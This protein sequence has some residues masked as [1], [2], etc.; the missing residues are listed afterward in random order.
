MCPPAANGRQLALPAGQ[1]Y[2]REPA[3]PQTANRDKISDMVVI[4]NVSALFTYYYTR[5]LDLVIKQ[6]SFLMT[7]IIPV[8]YGIETIVTI[9]HLQVAITLLNSQSEE[10]E[11][12]LSGCE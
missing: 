3:M 11:A 12:P 4:T 8:I 6:R 10:L 2:G 9:E 7:V 5:Y 1:G